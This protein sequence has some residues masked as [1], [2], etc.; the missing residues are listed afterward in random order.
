MLSG[1]RNLIF[2]GMP[3]SGKSTVGV[4]VAK[5]LGLGFIDTDLLIQQEA[6]STLQDIV[7]QKGYLAL[8]HIEEEVLLQLNVEKHV[9]STGGSAVY[10]E[11]AMQ[12]LKNSGVVVFLDISLDTVVARIGDYSL[13]GISKRPEQSLVE[14]YQERSALYSRYADIM[15]QG[16]ALSQEQVSESLIDQLNVFGKDVP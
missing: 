6:G 14:L 9:I 3:G 16:D 13:R 5:R 4:L 11:A 7:N 2:V 1:S 10:S 8:R 12:H 15:V